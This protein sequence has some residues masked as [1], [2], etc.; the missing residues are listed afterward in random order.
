M[1]GGARDGG[2]AGG[3][4]AAAPLGEPAA[5]VEAVRGGPADG[6]DPGPAAEGEELG[7]DRE[8][9]RDGNPEEDVGRAALGELPQD[10]QVTRSI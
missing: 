8:G 4:E 6:V 7:E 10:E 3:G 9:L 5:R 1:A 2:A